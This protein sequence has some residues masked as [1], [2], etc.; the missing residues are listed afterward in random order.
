MMEPQPTTMPQLPPGLDLDGGI[1]RRV[2][3]EAEMV[4]ITEL[5][6]CYNLHSDCAHS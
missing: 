5:V 6:M 2:I 1:F 3:V 4:A